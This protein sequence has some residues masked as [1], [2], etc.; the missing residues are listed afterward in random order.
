MLDKVT[1]DFIQQLKQYQSWYF[2]EGKFHW[3]DDE[4]KILYVNNYILKNQEN[5]TESRKTYTIYKYRM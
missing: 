2:N 5:A 4:P 3:N 1:P